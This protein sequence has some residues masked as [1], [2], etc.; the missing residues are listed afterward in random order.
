MLAI[1]CSCLALFVCLGVSGVSDKIKILPV[2]V[3]GR[4]DET[5][6]RNRL[7]MK[8]PSQRIANGILYAVKRG[9]DVINLSLGW[10]NSMDTAFMRNVIKEAVSKN[11]VVVRC[12]ESAG[13]E[14]LGLSSF[15]NQLW[16][17]INA[18][19]D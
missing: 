17:K 8:A 16:E 19:I 4:V 15:D 5:S 6:D 13:N 9:V 11:I 2:K 7:L 14:K 10:P 18:V 1:N 3:T 12:G